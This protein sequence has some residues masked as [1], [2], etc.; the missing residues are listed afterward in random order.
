MRIFEEGKDFIRP[1]IST[2]PGFGQEKEFPFRGK[3]FFLD[4]FPFGEY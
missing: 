4:S 3:E 2:D 1:K